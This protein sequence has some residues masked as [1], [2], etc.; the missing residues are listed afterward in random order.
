M[1]S[2]SD[3]WL[4]VSFI[5]DAAQYSRIA[6]L[7]DALNKEGSSIEVFVRKALLDECSSRGILPEETDREAIERL[8]LEGK[9]DQAAVIALKPFVQKV[10][11]EKKQK[12]EG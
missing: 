8:L 1:A 7:F 4:R 12:K 9:V 3:R 6:K 11:E 5:V 2:P 10:D